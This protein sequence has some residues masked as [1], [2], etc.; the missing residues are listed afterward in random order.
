MSL[1]PCQKPLFSLPEDLHYLNCA[2][3]SPLLKSVEAA[4]I[5]GVQRKRNPFAITPDDFFAQAEAVRQR[6]GQL[7]NAPTLQVALIP[8]VS[9]GLS[10]VA[11]NVPASAGQRVV[12]VHEEFPSDIY[13]LHR[14]CAEKSL[15]LVTI[16]PPT[17]RQD[18]GRRWNERLLE[19]I[20]PKTALVVLST[21]HWADGTRFDLTAIG[22]RCRD[23]GARLVV[24]GTQSV[25]AL[26]IDVQACGIDALICAGYK[27]LMGPYSLGMMYVSEAF[28]DGVPLEENW[29]NRL[30]SEDF[31]RLVAYEPRYKPGAARYNVGESGN[32]ILLPMMQRALDQILDW[33]PARIQAYDAALTQPLI[34][35]LQENG[36]GV[37]EATWRG[38]H[39]FGVTLPAHLDQA[40]T[41]TRLKERN[42]SVSARGHALRISTHLYN[43]PDDIAALIEVLAEAR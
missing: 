10:T 6:F 22:K 33:Q 31:N 39:L 5:E 8:S 20:T 15:D 29:V 32:F 26:P 27:W 30:G 17:A 42:I 18:R 12:V 9:Y 19:A 37:E 4:G 36:Y 1:L 3:M 7:V 38:E 16:E 25:G 34:A 14:L 41:L 35:F 28:N 2:Y 21:V 13:A 40:A 23:V 43:T 24:D 11:R